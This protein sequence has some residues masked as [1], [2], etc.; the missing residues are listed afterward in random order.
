MWCIGEPLCC[1][2]CP[3]C[4]ITESYLASSWLWFLPLVVSDSL[5]YFCYSNMDQIMVS[6][7]AWVT[8][9][10]MQISVDCFWC[11]YGVIKLKD[12]FPWHINST[13]W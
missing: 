8:Q 7:H 1:A 6:N 10:K 3:V 5:A 2:V 9:E 4:Q 12:P 11:S 13:A